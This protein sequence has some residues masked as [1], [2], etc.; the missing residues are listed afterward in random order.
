MP[1]SLMRTIRVSNSLHLKQNKKGTTQKRPCFF[2]MALKQR[3]KREEEEMTL[4]HSINEEKKHA[5]ARLTRSCRV[6]NFNCSSLAVRIKSI[7]HVQLSVWE[8]ADR[9][10]ICSVAARRVVHSYINTPSDSCYLLCRVK[11]ILLLV[12]CIFDH[13]L[14]LVNG[15]SLM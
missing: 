9:W 6:I 13:R 1:L 3:R 4:I 2:F 8:E 11:H 10:F 5:F 12:N 14:R 7:K 15:A